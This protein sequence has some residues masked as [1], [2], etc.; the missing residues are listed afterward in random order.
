MEV[1]IWAVF[2]AT[3]AIFGVGA[4]WYMVPFAKIWGTI[5]GFDKLSKEKQKEMEAK[6]GPWYGVQLVVTIL[7]A[8]V[9]AVLIGALPEM[10]AFFVA[11]LVWLGFVLPTTAS[12]MI[13]GGSPEGYVWHKIAITSGEA[14][15][16]LLVAAWVI[17]VM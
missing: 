17:S 8:W 13:F 15:V 6:M 11:F 9:L 5:H 4:F 16:H 14:L 12:N 7:S 2:A 10:S 3:V 1:N